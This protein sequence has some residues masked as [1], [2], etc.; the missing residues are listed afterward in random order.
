MAFT[1]IHSV[2]RVRRG[3]R[4]N[5]DRG[6]DAK[7]ES[8]GSISRNQRPRRIDTQL[9]LAG[10]ASDSQAINFQ[11]ECQVAGHGDATSG[12]VD[13]VLPGANGEPLAIVEAKRAVRDA[14]AGKERAALRGR[15]SGGDRKQ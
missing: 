5:S 2:K 10:W 8:A 7:G 11:A 4:P 3:R 9:R 12:F 15:D 6:G 1:P 14:L 13:Y